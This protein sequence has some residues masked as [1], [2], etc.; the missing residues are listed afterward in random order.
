MA[1]D[2]GNGEEGDENKEELQPADEPKFDPKELLASLSDD[3]RRALL[4]EV[5]QVLRIETKFYR[6]SGP[7]PRPE[8][9]EKYE[10]VRP[11][12]AGDIVAM[13]KRGQEIYAKG[14]DGLIVNDRWR[15]AV[16]TLIG[17]ALIAAAIIVAFWD[18]PIVS[19]LFGLAGVANTILGLIR[20]WLGFSR[21]PSTD[22][23]TDKEDS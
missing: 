3:Q 17:L 8:D 6:F 15:I 16:A 10:Q 12:T 20:E 21:D 23:D 7:L 19:A 13:A 22:K 9:F 14:Q 18:L 1:R 11:G 4:L 2:N 5:T